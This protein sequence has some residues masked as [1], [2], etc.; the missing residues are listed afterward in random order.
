[1]ARPDGQAEL[2]QLLDVAHGGIDEQRRHPSPL[3]L[4]GDQLAGE[5][6]RP[7]L[8]HRQNEHLARVRLGDGCVHHEVVVLCAAHRPRG[9][10]GP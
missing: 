4:R 7:R 9:P 2:A 3:G 6:D 8:G 1:M 5:G 10:G